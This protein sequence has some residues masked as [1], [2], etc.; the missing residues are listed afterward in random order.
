MCGVSAAPSSCRLPVKTCPKMPEE[1]RKGHL[2][3]LMFQMLQDNTHELA[4]SALGRTMSGSFAQSSKSMRDEQSFAG[5]GVVH[6]QI[7]RGT[8]EHEHS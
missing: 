5:R 6:C 8:Q 3:S 4:R 7:H 2:F 1:L